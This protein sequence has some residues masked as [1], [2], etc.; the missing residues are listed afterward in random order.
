M[1]CWRVMAG[2]GEDY[3]LIARLAHDRVVI[4]SAASDLSITVCDAL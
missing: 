4:A 1:I 2:Y 3:E